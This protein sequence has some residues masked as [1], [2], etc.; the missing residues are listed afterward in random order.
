[1]KGRMVLEG[2]V[3]GSYFEIS[4]KPSTGMVM[5]AGMVKLL[6]DVPSSSTTQSLTF[7]CSSST[8]LISMNSSPVPPGVVPIHMTSLITTGLRTSLEAVRGTSTLS[9]AATGSV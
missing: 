9:S 8:F 7:T 5:P 2:W 1:M 3:S 6:P 4:R